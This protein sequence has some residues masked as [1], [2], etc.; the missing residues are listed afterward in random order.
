MTAEQATNT[1]STETPNPDLWTIGRLL[2]WTTEYLTQHGADSPRL[3]AEV[4]LAAARKCQRIELYTCYEEEAG[5]DLRT[6]FREL[7][8]RRAGGEPV[9]YLVGHREFYSLSFQVSP[10]VLIPRPETEFLVI[11]VLDYL[12][13]LESD[14]PPQVVDVGTGSGIVA[15]CTA[16]HNSDAEITAI[17]IS[18]QALQVAKANAASHEVEQRIQFS[19]GNLLATLPA[20]QNLDV[21]ASNPPYVSEGE[22]QQLSRDVKDYEPRTALVGGDTGMELIQQLL[23]QAAD[24]LKVGGALF[25]E[26]SPMIAADLKELVDA[27]HRWEPA[28]FTNDLAGYA[29]I[30]KTYRRNT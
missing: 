2:T 5:E 4:L 3:D 7:V 16:K 21:I 11:E 12:K 26:I 29:R 30:L 25:L 23:P 24:R 27:D 15:I 10:A 13:E 6:E 9:A 22:Y 28:T 8:R 18:D 19:Q 14:A 1:E 17:D 20:H